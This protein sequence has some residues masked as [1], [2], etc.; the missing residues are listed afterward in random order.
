MSRPWMKF[1]PADWQ[2]DQ[3]LRMCS[4]AARG[5]WIECMAIMHR[6]EP[7]GHLLI[8][9]VIPT[10]TQLAVLVGT[11][12]DLVPALVAELETAGVFSRNRNRVV[13]SRR[14][15]RDEKK[16]KD[17]EASEKTGTLPG[18]RRGRQDAEK[19]RENLP[20]PGV[21]AGVAEQPPTFLEAKKVFTKEAVASLEASRNGDVAPRDVAR[22]MMDAWNE[23]FQGTAVVKAEKLVPSRVSTLNARFRDSFSRDLDQWREF[24]R[25]IRGT[26]FLIGDNERRWKADIDFA[27]KPI[28]I[29]RILEGKYDGKPCPTTGRR[30]AGF[31]A[32]EAR[33][34]VS[35]RTILEL[36]DADGRRAFA[37]CG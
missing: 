12:P 20:P 34:D 19:K 9:G 26:P 37:A 24:C 30:S 23:A 29:A 6:A 8:N 21:D 28:N 15:T 32:G 2:A 5:L 7:Y 14:M 36:M 22:A 11:Q 13:Y 1:Y 4:L 3:A 27:T 16:R 25:K 10:D 31:G 17:G 35:R 18:S 33:D